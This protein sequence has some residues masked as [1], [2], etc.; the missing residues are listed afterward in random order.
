MDC[1]PSTIEGNAFTLA[2]S[3]TDVDGLPA[4]PDSVSYKVLCLTNGTTVKSD[5]GMGAPS[6]SMDLVIDAAVNQLVSPTLNDREKRR[7]IVT[8]VTAGIPNKGMFDYY[9]KKETA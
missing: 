9:V 6:S 3:F 5:T 4:A 2:L 1:V 7:V 8:E